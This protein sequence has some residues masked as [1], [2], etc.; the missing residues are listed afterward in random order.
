MEIQEKLVQNRKNPIQSDTSQHKSSFFWFFWIFGH[1]W[2]SQMD[3][4]SMQ[5]RIK[6]DLK[7]EAEKHTRLDAIFYDF[8]WIWTSFRNQNR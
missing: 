6:V 7:I 2:T 5:K 8:P 1:F 3:P 4:K